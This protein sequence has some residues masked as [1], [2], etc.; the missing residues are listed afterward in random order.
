[1]SVENLDS[2][3]KLLEGSSLQIQVLLLDACPSLSISEGQGVLGISLRLK[4]EGLRKRHTSSILTVSIV[5]TFSET[6]A[7]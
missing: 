2:E 5:I 6:K 4:A 7:R 3:T 1:M